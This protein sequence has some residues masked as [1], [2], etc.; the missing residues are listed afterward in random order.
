MPS[1]SQDHFNSGAQAAHDI[2]AAMIKAAGDCLTLHG[3]D[4]NADA[5]LGAAFCLAVEK[6]TNDIDP[7]FKR[8]L[9]IQLSKA[10]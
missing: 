1:I 8:R 3:P 6:I 7:Q 2:A 4:P 10:Y 5:I 9:L